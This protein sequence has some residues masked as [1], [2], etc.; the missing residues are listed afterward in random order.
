MDYTALRERMRELKLSQKEAAK[1]IGMDEWQL[2]RKLNGAS[3]FTQE[4]ILRLCE[5]MEIPPEEIGIYFFR[6]KE[7]DDDQ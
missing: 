5:V 3:G 2:S 4:E 1:L 7:G 6:R